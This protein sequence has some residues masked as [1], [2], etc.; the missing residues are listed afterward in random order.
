[1]WLQNGGC[2]MLAFFEVLFGMKSH[3]DAG[4][5]TETALAA[6]IAVVAMV[7]AIAFMVWFGAAF[8]TRKWM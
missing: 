7:V 8:D 3:G 2:E 5:T 6:A 1:M 4:R